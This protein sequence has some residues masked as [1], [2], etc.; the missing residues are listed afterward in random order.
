MTTNGYKVFHSLALEIKKNMPTAKFAIIRADLEAEKYLK[1]Q[2]EIEYIFYN[3]RIKENYNNP[4]KL[5]PIDEKLLS[6]FES[7]IPYKSLWKVIAADRYLGR[8][9][10]NDTIGW[11]N[12]IGKNKNLILKILSNKIYEINKIFLEF[13]P[14]IFFPQ[15]GGGSVDTQIYYYLSKKYNVLY[16]VHQSTRIKNYFSFTDK[17]DLSFPFINKSTEF[18]IKNRFFKPSKETNE[19]Y[20]EIIND[21][22]T[23]IFTE[24]ISLNGGLFLKLKIFFL[25]IPYDFTKYIFSIKKEIINLK[26]NPSNVLK[27]LK[28]LFFLNYQQIYYSQLGKNTKVNDKYIYFPLHFTPEYSTSVQATLFQD[29]YFLIYLLSL[30]IP[31]N[32]TL[33]IK[34]HPAMLYRRVREKTFFKKIHRLPNVKFVSIF[35]SNKEL[36]QNSSMVAVITGTS[37]WEAILAGKPVINFADHIFDTLGLSKR[38]TNIEK[39]SS[40]IYELLNNKN[41]INK[42]KREFLIKCFLESVLENSFKL[43]YPAQ[44]LFEEGT[45]HQY[46]ISGKELYNGFIKYIKVNNLEK[47]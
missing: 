15:I 2:K 27:R 32:Y 21:I 20:N 18:K 3:D 30:S 38:I 12:S 6:D 46:A 35:S 47:Y 11:E 8:Q 36:I 28:Y 13:Q 7:M 1:T 26:I 29:Q 17:I 16:L 37:G 14:S 43:T 10:I 39:L 34:E 23:N 5:K 19:L 45:D 4:K 40:I 24:K 22:F 44:A 9:F 42:D 31:S 25:K 33:I 41:N